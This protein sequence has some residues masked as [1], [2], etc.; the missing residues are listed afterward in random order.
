[1]RQT[2]VTSVCGCRAKYL[3]DEDGQSMETECIESR[4]RDNTKWADAQAQTEESGHYDLHFLERASATRTPAE[5][6]PSPNPSRTRR[7][8][9]PSL[10]AQ[11]G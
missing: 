9:L 1:M 11:T 7:R 4:I 2:F 3:N 10:P 8:S 5:R 6:F